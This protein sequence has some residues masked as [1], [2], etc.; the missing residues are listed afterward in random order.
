MMAMNAQTM[1]RKTNPPVRIPAHAMCFPLSLFLW[2]VFS[3]RM[4]KINA[5]S[6]KIKLDRRQINPVKGTGTIPPHN[7]STVRIPRMR[8]TMECEFVLGKE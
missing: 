3:E 6:P 2:I 4:P 8:L 5:K 1:Q 7:A